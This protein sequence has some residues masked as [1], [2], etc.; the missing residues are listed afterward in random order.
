MFYICDL[1]IEVGLFVCTSNIICIRITEC[2]SFPKR[3]VQTSQ[4]SM[5]TTNFPWKIDQFYVMHTDSCLCF[6][7][8]IVVRIRNLCT[9]PLRHLIIWSYR[10]R[11]TWNY[12]A[13]SCLFVNIPDILL[14]RNI[15]HQMTSA[16]TYTRS[17]SII[18][19]KRYAWILWWHCRLFTMLP[20]IMS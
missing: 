20:L 14:Q 6:I 15:H 11:Q 10:L 2:T 13:L 8:K 18:T 9:I 12:V 19:L 16:L 17:Q 4:D 7:F 1:Y 5:V 3:L